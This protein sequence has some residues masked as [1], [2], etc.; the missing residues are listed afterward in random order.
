MLCVYHNK[1]IK[2]IMEIIEEVKDVNNNIRW[3][4]KTK[5]YFNL[6]HKRWVK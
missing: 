3:I 5:E 2:Y 4:F 6:K 1:I